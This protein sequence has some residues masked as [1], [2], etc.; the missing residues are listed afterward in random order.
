MDIRLVMYLAILT[1]GVIVAIVFS[2]VSLAIPRTI[3]TLASPAVSMEQRRVDVSKFGLQLT[4][5]L[6]HLGEQVDKR[7]QKWVHG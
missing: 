7:S 4:E 6:Y 3:E 2:I 1:A 5:D